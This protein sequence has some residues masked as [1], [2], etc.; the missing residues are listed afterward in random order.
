MPLEQ[1]IH[2][3]ST[4]AREKIVNRF[5]KLTATSALP[6]VFIYLYLKI[7]LLAVVC[8][9]IGFLFIFFVYLNKKSF[10][11]VSRAAIV[12]T[13]NLG[14]LFFS[15][16]LGY[17][18]GIYLYLFASPLLVYLLYDFNNK[19]HTFSFLF[20]YLITFIVISF[21]KKPFFSI[22]DKIS[23]DAIEFIYSFNFC[24]A[25]ILC[26]G[27]ITYFANNNDKYITNLISHRKDL[28]QEI[29]L[30]NKS[31][32]LLKK[33]LNER[34]IL[35]A[36]VHHRVKNNLAIISA[37][38]NMQKD[39]LKDESS[40]QIFEETK[41]RVYAMSLIHN[42]LYQNNSFAKIDFVQYVKKFCEN[43]SKSYQA[44]SK[45]EIEQ[46][47]A[48]ISLEI[49]TAIPLGLIL[50]ELITNSLKHAFN[51]QSSGKITIGL[52]NTENK[53]YKFW[54]S[55]SGVGM[56]AEIMNMTNSMG[57]NIIKSLVEQIDGEINYTNNNGS[58]FII[59]I[60]VV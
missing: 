43:I 20:L 54:V 23:P 28:E 37:L 55:D 60:P 9:L 8:G 27:L 7:Y 52:T 45:I 35:L 4:E 40:K 18:S 12:L 36:E 22:T 51:D 33:S 56:D 49:K 2:I 24:S 19:K 25:F 1:T 3:Q 38:I 14:V 30:R 46:Q 34:E 21:N 47:V 57:M 59:T 15:M 50:N 41:N 32:E 11:K 31:E 29:N 10:F 5:C 53:H 13:T 42:L 6:S 39:K 44:K 48:N 26:F 58:T 17:D 16:Y